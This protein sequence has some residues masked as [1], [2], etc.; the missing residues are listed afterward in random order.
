MP[1][2][3]FSKFYHS[4]YKNFIYFLVPKALNSYNTYDEGYINDVHK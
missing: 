2:A 4:K 3:I 1:T